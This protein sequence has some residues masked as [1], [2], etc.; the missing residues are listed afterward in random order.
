MTENSTDD[1]SAP[2]RIV[3]IE[4]KPFWDAIDA[5]NFVVA[6]CPCGACYLRSQTC[7]QCRSSADSLRWTAA[8]R[9]ATV[10][11]FVVFDKPY[12]PYF[13]GRLPYVV[14]VVSLQE[15]PEMITNVV[16]CNVETLSIGQ[17]VE[18]IIAERGGQK[19]HQAT[20]RSEPQ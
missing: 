16:G 17:A 4:D 2:Q 9:N 12:H 15:G 19:I 14:G 7:L 5:G 1:P 8:S 6:H 20:V 13:E 11:T 10:R 3:A 18:I